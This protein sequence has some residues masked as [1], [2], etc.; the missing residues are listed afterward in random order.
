MF[1]IQAGRVLMRKVTRVII[2]R[3]VAMI[4]V[5]T[6]GRTVMT[7]DVTD[8]STT[9]K[10]VRKTRST[11]T[12]CATTVMVVGGARKVNDDQTRRDGAD[13]LP[14]MTDD[15]DHPVL[16]MIEDVA[17]HQGPMMNDVVDHHRMVNVVDHQVMIVDVDRHLTTERRADE[18]DHSRQ[19]TRRRRSVARNV[20]DSTRKRRD[21]DTR[22][23]GDAQS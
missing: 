9:E 8:L 11:V 2:A 16:T 14:M 3:V 20:D 15:V 10:N 18:V 7:T 5:V 17:H 12:W 21:G 19:G 4:T 1:D 22:R 6:K 13:H 23:T